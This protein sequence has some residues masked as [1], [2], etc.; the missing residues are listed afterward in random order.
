MGEREESIGDGIV[1]CI[2]T[3]DLEMKKKKVRAAMD[4]KEEEEKKKEPEHYG[5]AKS[6]N[7]VIYKAVI[8]GDINGLLGALDPEHSLLRQVSPRENTVLHIAAS[9]GHEHLVGPIL[10]RYPDHFRSKNTK[11]DLPLHLAASAGHLSTVQSLISNARQFASS[12]SENSE[13]RVEEIKEVV[14]EANEE[15]NTPLHLALKNHH[16]QVAVFLFNQNQEASCCLNK[17][18][19]S[20]LY[21]AV[22]AG[23]LELVSLMMEYIIQSDNPDERLKS[24]TSIV[25]AAIGTRKRELLDKLLRCRSSLIDSVDENGRTPLSYAASIGY[26]DGVCCILDLKAFTEYTYNR[27]RDGFY[28]IHMASRNGHINV[29]Q[30]FL[31]RCPDSRELL[32]PKGQNILHVAAENGRANAVS[33][34]LKIPELENLIN[35]RDKDGNTA[36][37][38]ASKYGYPKVVSILTWDKRVCLELVNE[39][40]MTA[41]AVL[42]D[43]DYDLTSFRWRLTWQA[44]R[45]ANVPR[46]PRGKKRRSYEPDESYYKDRINTLLLVATLVATV[47]FAAG[48]TMPGGHNDSDPN[49]GMAIMLKAHTFHIFLISNTIAMYCSIVVAVVLIWAQ[50]GDL[51]LVIASLNLALPL[52]GIALTMVSLAFMA[53]VY[54]VVSNLTWLANLILIIGLPRCCHWLYDYALFWAC[55]WLLLVWV[56]CADLMWWSYIKL[57]GLKMIN[58]PDLTQHINTFNQSISD[59]LRIDVKFDDED[60]ALM[61]LTSLPTF[62]EHLVTTL[63]WRKE[64]LETEEVIAALLAYNQRKQ[65]TIEFFDQGLVAKGNHDRG[66]RMERDGSDNRNCRSKSKN[67]NI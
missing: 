21:L 32:N 41:L 62:Y 42:E 24:G 43:Y 66:M 1:P 13:A 20:P 50:L 26:L 30:E 15:E 64:I 39:E 22:E 34:M 56:L 49:K 8:A 55:N 7:P 9:I 54:L 10:N 48:F 4:M 52:L 47:T 58:D 14:K 45:Y 38:L 40:G 35:E 65:N 51:N 60:K 5:M 2:A 59:L 17:E 44:L 53:A 3:F 61:F 36:L 67:K 12:N 29:I 18:K 27:D 25:H 63:F 11:G 28:P 6:V 46:A 57:Y 19:K 33:Y 16:Y 31:R 37:H 23:Y